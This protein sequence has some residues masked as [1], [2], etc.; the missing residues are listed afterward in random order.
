MGLVLLQDRLTGLLGYG[1]RRLASS[2]L[3]RLEDIVVG[4]A[5]LPSPL[6]GLV[7]F[8]DRMTQ[9]LGYGIRRLAS[10]LL[11]RLEDIVIGSA[12][13]PSLLMAPVLLQD[14]LTRLLGYGTFVPI[15]L[16][17]GNNQILHLQILPNPH[18]SSQVLLLD[19]A[20]WIGH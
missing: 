13:L 17:I 11:V 2:L 16:V 12:L 15:L 3:V 6:M 9:L 7:L 14:R 19:L 20:S 5:L 1:I 18:P 8:Q 10:S 4:S